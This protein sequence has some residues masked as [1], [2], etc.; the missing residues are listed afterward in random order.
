[1]LKIVN[2]MRAT[3]HKSLGLG[4]DTCELVSV[5]FQ[6]KKGHGELW[7]ECINQI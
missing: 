7:F 3:P 5:C 6:L 1:M 2:A 4:A